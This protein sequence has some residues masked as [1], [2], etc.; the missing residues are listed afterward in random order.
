MLTSGP[1]PQFEDSKSG[2]TSLNR[3]SLPLH[4][5]K[6]RISHTPGVDRPGFTIIYKCN[7]IKNVYVDLITVN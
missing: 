2:K 5:K 6:K 3:R 7:Q 1:I 4:F